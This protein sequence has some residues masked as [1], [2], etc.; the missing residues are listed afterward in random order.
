MFTRFFFNRM[1]P[2]KKL[3][4]LRKKGTLIGNRMRNSCLVSV[5]MLSDLFVE[6]IFPKESSTEV[7]E[8]IR[9]FHSLESLNGYLEDDARLNLN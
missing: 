2:T 9:V 4:Y 7:P 5:Y 1:S 8:E 6:V 3:D